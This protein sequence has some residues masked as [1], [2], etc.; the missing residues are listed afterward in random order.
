MEKGYSVDAIY[1][2]FSRAF[3]C[4]RHELL[5]RK[6]KNYGISSGVSAWFGSYLTRRQIQVRV[7]HQL[8]A[9]YVTT[10]GVSP[11]SHLGPVLF[12]LYVQDL[13]SKLTVDCLLYADDLKLSRRITG[14]ADAH[15]LQADLDIVAH[16]GTLNSL[17]VNPSSLS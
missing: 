14:S 7:N 11:G 3:N 8:S 1:L 4:F 13:I 12:L 9:L 6:L 2:D 17:H 10:S 16:W 15:L 5:V